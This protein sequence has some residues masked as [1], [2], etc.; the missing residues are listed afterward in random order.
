MTRLL[1]A[2]RGIPGLPHLLEA[3]GRRAV[4]I[5]TAANPL[6]DPGI[7][8][9]VEL[10]LAS[11]G[12]DVER[13]DLDA[14]T[15]DEVHGRVTAADVVAVSGGDPF[16]LLAAARRTRLGAAAREA[17]ADGAVYVG[18]SAGAMVAGP[19]LEP[20]RLT[21]P[22]SP[23]ADLDLTG[24]GLTEVLVLPHHDR[25][26][27]AERHAT[28]EAAFAG[29]VR[30]QALRDGELVIDDGGTISVVHQG[31]QIRQ[32]EEEHVERVASVLD[33]SRLGQPDGVY[34]VAWD[35]DQPAGHVHLALTD[36]AEVQDLLVRAEHRR[37]GI[38]RALVA[39]AEQEA[40][41]RGFDR[42]RVMVSID[43]RAAQALYRGF[44]F[45]DTGTP[46]RRVRGTITIR[47]GPIEV[48]DTLLTWEKRLAVTPR[49]THGK[50]PRAGPHR[51]G[52]GGDSLP[53]WSA[54]GWVPEHDA[55]QQVL[56]ILRQRD[57]FDPPHLLRSQRVGARRPGDRQAA[58]RRGLRRHRP[59]CE[60]FVGG[61]YWARTRLRLRDEPRTH[62]AAWLRGPQV[63]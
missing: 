13:V 39:G 31:V 50:R 18:Y 26:G 56:V 30:L 20:L 48:D 34:L 22:F 37:R 45:R 27:R 19:T 36:P 2:S 35:G 41:A 15:P 16:Y 28:A 17:L 10:E 9:E 62:I 29:R 49:S 38:A 57:L 1:L 33:L 58:S 8:A 25:P 4:L 44:G 46:P 51:P 14:A 53:A 6:A 12:L 24:M 7:A 52:P 59:E 54:T 5:P 42:L 63:L 11:A 47:T 40:L 23:P 60:A 43:N 55:D 3:R 61:R 21:S 32:L